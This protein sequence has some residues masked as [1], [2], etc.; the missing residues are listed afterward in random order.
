MHVCQP[1]CVINFRRT[2]FC[3]RLGFFFLY[4][5]FYLRFSLSGCVR[6]EILWLPNHSLFAIVEFSFPSLVVSMSL[7]HLIL[8]LRKLLNI[9]ARSF[10]W[11]LCLE[12]LTRKITFIITRYFRAY[13]RDITMYK[14]YSYFRPHKHK[15]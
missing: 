8:P 12:L 1:R 5:F 9:I 15:P 4:F 3:R 10:W 7:S 14:K 11:G 13:K 2:N 6:R